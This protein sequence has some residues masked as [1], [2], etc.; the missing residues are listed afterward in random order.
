MQ[1]WQSEL[2]T[3]I[4]NVE[5]LE[6]T[7]EL[8]P[9]EAAYFRNPA[10]EE[11]FPLR[12][13]PHYLALVQSDPSGAL[14]RMAVPRR[15]EKRVLAFESADPL[16]ELSHEVVPRCI[17]R[18]PDRVLI[19]VTDACALY[20]RHCFRRRFTADGA[21]GLTE[22]QQRDIVDYLRKH[23]EVHEVIL[24]GGD[25]LMLVDRVL[26]NLLADL[27]SVRPDLVLRVSSRMPVVLPSRVDNALVELLASYRPLWLVIQVN[28]PLEFSPEFLTAVAKASAAGIPLLSQTVLLRSVNDDL[29]VLKRLFHNLIEVG[30]KPYYLFQGDLVP[31]TSHLRTPLDVSLELY[32]RLQL[33]LSGLALPVFALDLP[34]GGG[35][36]RLHRE[37]LAGREEGNFLIRDLEGKLYRYPAEGS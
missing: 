23:P 11:G 8:D 33:E 36:I 7:L 2:N 34:E 26:E 9:D 18:Y 3:V 22:K 14:R 12:I 35:K 10:G 20:C 29:E 27:R 13:T 6:S 25:P 37:S 17:H 15:D 32:R 1:K 19:L 24:S 16:M 31:G 5:D 21:G 28:H 4:E 30:I